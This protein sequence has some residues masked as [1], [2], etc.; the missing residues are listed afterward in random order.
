MLTVNDITGRKITETK[1][2]H[3]TEILDLTQLPN[4]M[5]FIYYSDDKNKKVLKITK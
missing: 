2:T 4:G 5:Y 1:I 3:V